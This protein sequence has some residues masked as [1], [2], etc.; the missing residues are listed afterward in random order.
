MQ[1]GV[2]TFGSCNCPC[3]GRGRKGVV[4]AKAWHGRFPFDRE[5]APLTIAAT[6]DQTKYLK[7]KSTVVLD[8]V[9]DTQDNTWSGGL[10]VT[11]TDHAELHD[12]R[13]V[14]CEVNRYSGL[15]T[16]PECVEERSEVAAQG[17][18]SRDP[19]LLFGDISLGGGAYVVWKDVFAALDARCGII[20]AQK[21]GPWLPNSSGQ[22]PPAGCSTTY[23]LSLY[24]CGTPAE[25]E[26]AFTYHQ[27]T[28]TSTPYPL[29]PELVAT[30]DEVIDQVCHVSLTGTEIEVEI[31]STYS[32]TETGYIVAGGHALVDYPTSSS[33]VSQAEIH[34]IIT[35]SIPYSNAQLNA[36][37]DELLGQRLLTDDTNIPWQNGCTYPLV[38]RDELA[39]T[40]PLYALSI[41]GVR[42]LPA[43]CNLRDPRCWECVDEAWVEM[44][45]GCPT[46]AIVNGSG[47]SSQSYNVAAWRNGH[48][49]GAFKQYGMYG[50]T[51]A[52]YLVAC[53]YAETLAVRAAHNWFRPCGADRS[54]LDDETHARYPAAWPIC[55]SL[56]VTGASN[57]TPIV[58]TTATNYLQTGDLVDIAGVT[59]NTA[60]NGTDWSV[61]VLG[62]TTFQLDGS[63][64]NGA[65][66][67]GGTVKNA[68]STSPPDDTA[69]WANDDPKGD[70]T[71]IMYETNV[72]DIEIDPT[73]RQYNDPCYDMPQEIS[74]LTVIE[75]NIVR[76]ANPSVVCISPS[77]ETWAN[78]VTH[79]FPSAAMPLVCDERFSI[80]PFSCW[81][82]QIRQRMLDPIDPWTVTDPGGPAQ[83]YHLIFVEGRA[84]LPVG[85]PS[86]QSVH[87]GHCAPYE[88]GGYESLV[89]CAFVNILS[90]TEITDLA[91]AQVAGVCPALTGLVIPPLY[92]CSDHFPELLIAGPAVEVP[93]CDPQS[94]VA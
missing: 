63:V 65:W 58:I 76:D 51:L 6:P 67:G 86:L 78:G 82:G 22:P 2:P 52:L 73:L 40:E 80:N 10:P 75:G 43:L 13:V 36:D 46:G 93:C 45:E 59:G 88:I 23:P 35:L 14:S 89:L 33:S 56:A 17:G 39:P 3:G 1:P 92:W 28:H 24:P 26:A 34:V 30:F 70:Y 71:V 5:C 55:G 15:R 90:I 38:T 64:G 37:V 27:E 57:T 83:R 91:D 12:Q 61:T 31:V 20:S 48:P 4:A 77:G 94:D 85:A 54:L 19:N 53:K 87:G 68:A 29:E 16:F 11:V 21:D 50:G 79:A 72:R 18:T 69:D 32:L 42:C 84:S 81:I 25:I 60:A 9:A 8:S 47:A 62:P 7:H 66:A 74:G 49:A 44:A 41:A